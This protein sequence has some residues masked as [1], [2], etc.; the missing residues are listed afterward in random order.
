MQTMRLVEG[1]NPP[2]RLR[3]GSLG[4]TLLTTGVFV[5]GLFFLNPNVITK[6]IEVFV[7]TSIPL[8]P[9]PPPDPTPIRQ[10]QK[11]V[12]HDP[13]PY[14]PPTNPPVTPT[15]TPHI[16]LPPTPTL[17]GIP[18]TT[19]VETATQTKSPLMIGP[20]VD[21]RYANN[22]QPAYPADEIRGGNA[23]RV[24][25]RVL[26]GTDGRVKDIER[27]SAASESFWDA[28]RRQALSK[29]RFKPATRD[30][31][32]YETWKIMNVSF[33]LNQEQ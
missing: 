33:V 20:S 10:T 12:P 26:I 17:P 4:L 16:D 18:E 2:S 21:P 9:P 14:T 6:P 28:T 13:Q 27:V 24:T 32:P 5:S 3:P 15:D 7:G 29:W 1:Y 23:G 19:S 30:G 22:F 8:P 11:P 31:E 25:V